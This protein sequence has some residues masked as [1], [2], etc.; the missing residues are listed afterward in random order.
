MFTVIGYGYD[1]KDKVAYSYKDAVHIA[2]SMVWD[3]RLDYA[4]I[5]DTETDLMTIVFWY[6]KFYEASVDADAP[7]FADSYVLSRNLGGTWADIYYAG[8][9]YLKW[10]YAE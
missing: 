8:G 6:G 3:M 4:E 1:S 2:K 10:D 9:Y 7:K 5:R